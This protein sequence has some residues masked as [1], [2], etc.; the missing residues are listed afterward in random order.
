MDLAHTA[1]ELLGC[2]GH[3]LIK[4]FSVYGELDVAPLLLEQRRSRLL[5]AFV[6][7]DC[8]I[9]SSSDAR[10]KFPVSAATK[11]YIRCCQLRNIRSF[12]SKFVI[13]ITL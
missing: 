10:V 5:N 11:K 3:V 4:R 9:N 13:S 2:A 7:A 1:V 12:H 6:S 8:V